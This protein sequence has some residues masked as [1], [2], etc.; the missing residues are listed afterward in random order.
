M[1]LG[2]RRG[3]LGSVVIVLRLFL[4]PIDIIGGIAA[5]AAVGTARLIVVGTKRP[6]F[7][8]IVF[9]RRNLVLD[10][11]MLGGVMLNSTLGKSVSVAT[12]DGL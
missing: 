8:R 4:L 11:R 10:A 5:V 1:D 12:F 2:V 3:I 7:L 9:R 6:A